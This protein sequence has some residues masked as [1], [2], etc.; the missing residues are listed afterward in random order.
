MR[1]EDHTR[2]QDEQRRGEERRRVSRCQRGDSWDAGEERIL[3]DG[4]QRL[5]KVFYSECHTYKLS[6]VFCKNL[7]RVSSHRIHNYETRP[8]SVS[9]TSRK[10]RNAWF[11]IKTPFWALPENLCSKRFC[12][13]ILSTGQAS[14]MWILR[15]L[16]KEKQQA[17]T[18]SL[19]RWHNIK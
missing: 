3:D 4:V 18:P 5:C 1:I 19:Q 13:V 8:K 6:L 12:H 16:F 17:L 10:S 14:Y 2:V 7:I 15:E 9:E 11:L